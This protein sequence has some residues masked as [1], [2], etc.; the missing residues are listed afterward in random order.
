MSTPRKRKTFA[1][2]CDQIAEERMRQIQVEGWTA[3]H[4][5]DH[6][7]GELALA[8]AAYAGAATGERLYRVDRDAGRE[9]RLLDAFP[10][11]WA[12]YWDKR[13]FKRATKAEKIRML[14]KAGALIAAE[15]DRMQRQ[16]R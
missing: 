15:I 2:G 12:D 5:D 3:D 10:Q 11:D 8:G 4:D 14:V 9:L 1:S 13:K 6:E 7:G 16:R